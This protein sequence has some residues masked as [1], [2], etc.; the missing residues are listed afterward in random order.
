[1]KVASRIT[2]SAG[3]YSVNVTLTRTASYR[4]EWTGVVTSPV[5]RIAAR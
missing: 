1:M 4:V 3:A 2:D 5:R